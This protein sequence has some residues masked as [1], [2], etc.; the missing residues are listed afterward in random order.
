MEPGFEIRTQAQNHK[1]SPGT[2]WQPSDSGG[3]RG[4]VLGTRLVRT[5]SECDLVQEASDEKKRGEG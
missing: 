2:D 5:Q 1:D 4:F 3:H